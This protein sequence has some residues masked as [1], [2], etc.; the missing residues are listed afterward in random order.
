MK[1]FLIVY[2]RPVQALLACKEYHT[3]HEALSVRFQLERVLTLDTSLEIVVLGAP[4]LDTLRHTHS[5]YFSGESSIYRVW[6]PGFE[7]ILGSD[8]A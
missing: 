5:R 4:D 3:S 1:H 7:G 8:A 2:Y 6:N